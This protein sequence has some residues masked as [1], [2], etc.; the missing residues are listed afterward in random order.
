MKRPPSFLLLLCCE[1]INCPNFVWNM[2]SCCHSG[3]SI[4]A[5][6]SEH[7]L[8]TQRK[9]DGLSA[10]TNGRNCLTIDE[11]ILSYLNVTSVVNLKRT[12][13]GCLR[14]ASRHYFRGRFA[15]SF[16][17]ELMS[18]SRAMS[19]I[20]KR[21]RDF[22]LWND[23]FETVY[24]ACLNH[25]DEANFFLW[26][27]FAMDLFEDRLEV[28]SDGRYY[29]PFGV[30]EL[31]TFTW[32]GVDWYDRYA[33]AD[34]CLYYDFLLAALFVPEETDVELEPCHKVGFCRPNAS[35][36]MKALELYYASQIAPTACV[37]RLLRIEWSACHKQ[38]DGYGPY[39]CP[40]G[41]VHSHEFIMQAPIASKV[42]CLLKLYHDSLLF[43]LAALWGLS[44]EKRNI[45]DQGIL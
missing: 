26:E 40:E 18:F 27:K 6:L 25:V 45:Y 30:C 4:F 42:E 22:F 31:S 23:V 20:P 21:I 39:H 7:A 14:L 10:V 28:A 19:G 1:N 15:L 12:F 37:D 17:Q 43:Y 13:V 34:G 29:K 8:V 2:E 44:L 11:V 3:L 33:F 32:S 24:L 41:Y 35:L 36:L 38:C 9:E 5:I 16:A